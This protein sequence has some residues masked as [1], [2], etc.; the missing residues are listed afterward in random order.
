M[1]ITGKEE[2][3]SIM[4]GGEVRQGTNIKSLIRTAADLT[5]K[6]DKFNIPDADDESSDEE[7]SSPSC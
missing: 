3:T 5:T 1:F 2:G 6:F 4:G 7:E